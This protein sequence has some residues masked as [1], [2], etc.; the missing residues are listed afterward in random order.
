MKKRKKKWLPARS[1]LL[2]PDTT[3]S[4]QDGHISGRPQLERH[5][6]THTHIYKL[7]HIHMHIFIHT[8]SHTHTYIYT[9]SILIH[10][11]L[12]IYAHMHTVTHTHPYTQTNKNC[13]LEVLPQSPIIAQC[14]A[15]RYLKDGT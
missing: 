12:H 8:Q 7:T 6:Y 1:G 2:R 9:Q 15:D 5:T 13:Q 3:L 10:I 4:P 11:Y 14:L